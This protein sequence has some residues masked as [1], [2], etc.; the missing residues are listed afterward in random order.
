MT[1]YSAEA[2]QRCHRDFVPWLSKILLAS[3]HAA[4]GSQS[5]DAVF[6]A[7]VR[8]RLLKHNKKYTR[9]FLKLIAHRS[10]KGES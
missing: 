10:E 3:L 7:E 2:I 5:F 8:K 1:K 6:E 9:D 4:E